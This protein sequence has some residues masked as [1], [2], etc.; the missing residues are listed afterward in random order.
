[1]NCPAT[2]SEDKCLCASWHCLTGA[3]LLP[4]RQCP[5]TVWGLA[6]ARDYFQQAV[7]MRSLQFGYYES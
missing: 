6:L 5:G 2:I 7:W 1:M 4:A 3:D